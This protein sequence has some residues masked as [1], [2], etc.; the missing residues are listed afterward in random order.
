M[1]I[2]CIAEISLVTT[3]LLTP[4]YIY[5]RMD[6]AVFITLLNAAY[7]S[8]A[9]QSVHLALCLGM[10][11]AGGGGMGIG[12]VVELVAI[13]QRLGGQV[14]VA[15]GEDRAAVVRERYGGNGFLGEAPTTQILEP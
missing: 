3:D 10:W 7:S 13:V 4:H 11:R 14:G 15:L 6:K 8:T 9:I 1:Q 5:V 2:N 12:Q